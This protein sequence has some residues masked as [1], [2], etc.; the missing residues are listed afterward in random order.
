MN[1]SAT[2]NSAEQTPPAGRYHLD[3]TRTAVRLRT[4]H[5]FGLGGVSGTVTLR[6][7]EL[8]IGEPITATTLRA[9]LD[10]ASGWRLFSRVGGGG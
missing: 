4:R 8:I 5:L 10:A 9:V 2:P 1:S 7:A 3:P 6:E